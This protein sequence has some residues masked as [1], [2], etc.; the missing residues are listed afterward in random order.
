MTK[1]QA[2]MMHMP[3]TTQLILRHGAALHGG[4]T[5]STF[6]GTR[7]HDA[8]FACIAERAA[9]LAAALGAIGIRQGERVATL[10]WNHQP[11]LEAYLAVPAMGAVLHTLNLRLFAEQLGYIMNDAK[12]AALIVDGSLLPL[13]RDILPQVPSLRAIIVVGP[14]DGAPGFAGAVHDYEALIAAHAPLAQWPALEETAAAAACYTSGTTGNP[15][16]VVYSHRTIVLHTMASLGADTFAIA[17]GDRILLLPPMFHAN[18]WGLPF[19]AWFAGADLLLPGPHLQPPRARAMIEAKRPTFTA[20]VPTLVGDLLRAHREQPLD[21]SSF[22]VIVVGGSAVSPS[23]IEE[24]RGT[25]GV[26]VLQGWGMTETSPLCALSIPPRDALPEDE[27]H[28]RSASGRPVPGVEVRI[29][30]DDG[31]PLPHDGVSV[32]AL[33]LRGPWIAAGYHGLDNTDVLSRDGWLRTGDVGTIDARGYV[34]ITDRQKDLIKSGGEWISSI[35]LENLLEA[36]PGVAAAA[37]IAVPDPRWEERPLAIIVHS[38]DPVPPVELRRHL[39]GHV[40]RF[41]LPDYWAS[42]AELPRTGVGKVDKKVLREQVAGGR[43]CVIHD[44]S[45]V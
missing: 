36:H 20:T 22:R 23:L 31:A 14:A 15:K 10:C 28:W 38:G 34:R 35:E 9:R 19:S 6:D 18:A 39:A 4:S 45:P 3:L 2:T 8:T 27:T 25:W 37:V 17:Q 32:G 5:V 12:D 29:I 11:H 33:Q 24:V 43:V 21:M 42:L 26:A 13:I 1:M 7:F 40:A 16:G 44:L 30:G 41:W